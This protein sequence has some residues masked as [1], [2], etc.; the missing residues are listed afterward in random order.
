MKCIRIRRSCFLKKFFFAQNNLEVSKKY[1]C[2]S[3]DDITTSPNDPVYLE[4]TAK[5]VRQLNSKG[6]QLGIIFRRCP[7]DFS[8]RFD[9]VLEKYADTIVA[10]NPKWEKTGNDWNTILPTKED[11]NLQINTIA[12]SEMV[13]NLGSTMAFDYATHHKA[14]AFINYDVAHSIQPD[15]TVKKIYDYVHFRSMPSKDSVLWINSPNSME[16]IILQGLENPDM[17]VANAKQWFEKINQHPIDEAS[18]RII[19]A[20]QEIIV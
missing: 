8:D 2:Y 5:A 12:H 1:I 17:I 16:S 3:G 15:W 14:C 19:Q 10:V 7:V 6:Y 9:D 11:L 13:I 18:K 20:I 4:D